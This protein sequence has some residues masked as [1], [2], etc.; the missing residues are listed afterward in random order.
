MKKLMFL[1]LLAG[2][3]SGC[4]TV[5]LSSPGSLAG[6]DVKGAQGKADK[7]LFLSNEGYYFFQT[8]PVVCGDITW[9]TK[10]KEIE[11]GSAF[12]SN[13]LDGDL[14]MNVPTETVDYMRPGSRIAQ[15]GFVFWIAGVDLDAYDAFAA[16]H[17]EELKAAKQKITE[18][19]G[20]PMFCRG[21]LEH[22]HGVVWVHRLIG[23]LHQTEPEEMTFIDTSA[24]HFAVHSWELMKENL[25]GF[26]NSFIML[27]APQLGTSGGRRIIGR[28]YLTDK[29]MDRDEP[30]EDTILPT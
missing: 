2:V 18:G 3:L 22:Q 21:L 12:F 7:M 1:V 24:R 28:Y 17:P 25:P 20:R 30:F 11:G 13:Q 19:G 26:E 4:A 27:S 29:D 14:L 10:E 8:F 5:K 6:V 23:S 15:F 16:E 9:N